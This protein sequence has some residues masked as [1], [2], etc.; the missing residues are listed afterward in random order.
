MFVIQ[1]TGGTASRNLLLNER[2][3]QIIPPVHLKSFS[4]LFGQKLILCINFSIDQ[5]VQIKNYLFQLFFLNLYLT[6]G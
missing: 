1:Q 3:G 2:K 5:A 4:L 6:L